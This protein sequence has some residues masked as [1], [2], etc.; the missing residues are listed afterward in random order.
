MFLGKFTNAT[1]DD[2]KYW[3]SETDSYNTQSHIT[4]QKSGLQKTLI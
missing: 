4:K 1:H 2:N 3:N